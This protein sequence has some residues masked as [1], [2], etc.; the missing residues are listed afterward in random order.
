MGVARKILGIE[1]RRDRKEKKLLL[2][3]QSYIEKA[4]IKK[5]NMEDGK[6]TQVPLAGLCPI[7]VKNHWT[8][9]KWLLRYRKTTSNYGLKFEKTSNTLKLEGFI[10]AD[11]A[12]N[13]DTR[14]SITSYCF[15]LNSCCINWKS[16]LQHVVALSTKKFEFMT[17]TEAFKEATWIK[18][19]LQEIGMLKEKVSMFS[20]N[21]SAI[22][23]SKNPVY[24]ER[25][26]HIH[27]RMFWI[28]DKIELGEIELEKVPSD[29]NTADPGT[30]MLPVS[31]FRY[32]MDLLKLGPV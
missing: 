28:E 10:N 31:K 14:K 19:I 22:H 26:K 18:G 8:G 6:E 13:K 9:L 29:E 15:Q 23:L 2:T 7:L 3:Q 11:Y 4:V 12:S 1:I 21:Q 25:S 24:H 20:D 5:F 32:F 17:I 30:K 27:I 16:Q